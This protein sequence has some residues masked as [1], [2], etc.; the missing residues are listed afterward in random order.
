[1]SPL[2]LELGGVESPDVRHAFEQIALQWQTAGTGTTGGGGIQIVTSLPA[3]GSDGDEVYLTT[4]GSEYVWYAGAWH[5]ISPGPTGPM[6]PEGPAGPQGLQGVKGDTGATGATGPAGPQGDP[7][8]QGPQGIE[9]P[10][11]ATGLTGPQGPQGDPGPQ[12]L[13]GPQGVKGDTGAAG[14]QGPAGPQGDPGLQGPQGIAG[15][16]GPEGPQG[17][18]GIQGPQGE[19]GPQGPSGASTFVSGV[20]APTAG[21]GVDGALYLD[22]VSGRMYGPKA[23]GAW[24]AAPI[25]RLVTDAMTYA[26]ET[27]GN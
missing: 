10:Q 1:V 4:D 6:G 19:I 9:G 20:G 15:E 23:A 16:T 14:A 22:T 27:A 3:S 24:P 2:S 11:G 12:G 21:V 17:P 5:K 8:P 18:Q 26:Q 13:Q 25:G 7:G